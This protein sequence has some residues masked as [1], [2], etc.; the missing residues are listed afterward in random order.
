MT[1][2]MQVNWIYKLENLQNLNFKNHKYSD[3][4]F[5]RNNCDKFI[6][7]CYYV[8]RQLAQ[9]KTLYQFFNCF[10]ELYRFVCFLLFSCWFCFSIL[11]KECSHLRF[12]CVSFN[13]RVIS[14]LKYLEL[15]AYM[16]G[17]KVT[18][19]SLCS[20]NKRKISILPRSFSTHGFLVLQIHVI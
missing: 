10:T 3:K 9:M 4:A 11:L 1:N 14:G 8:E 17:K 7:D 12:A 20:L 13:T 15:L 19:L 2:E 18:F 16:N 5:L 6:L